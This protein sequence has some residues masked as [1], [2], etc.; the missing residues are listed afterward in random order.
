MNGC[1]ISVF[2]HSTNT[3]YDKNENWGTK[4]KVF[5]PHEC[6]RYLTLNIIM[7]WKCIAFNSDFYCHVRELIFRNMCSISLPKSIKVE[8]NNIQIHALYTL[9]CFYSS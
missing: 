8:K 2:S 5:K 6:V 9:K 3:S 7:G 1:T 4:N